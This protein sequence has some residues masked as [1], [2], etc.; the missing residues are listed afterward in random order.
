MQDDH[1]FPDVRAMTYALIVLS[2][3]S[4]VHECINALNAG[5]LVDFFQYLVSLLQAMHN[6]L[7]ELCELNGRYEL[8]KCRELA[9]GSLNKSALVRPSLQS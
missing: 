2:I 7:F 8:Q 3:S 1:R 9:F 6:T 5:L 4:L